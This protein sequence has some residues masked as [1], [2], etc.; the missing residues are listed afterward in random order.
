MSTVAVI[1]RSSIAGRVPDEDRL[2]VPELAS[3]SFG[4]RQR[5]GADP[6]VHRLARQLAVAR[7]EIAIAT[8]ATRTIVWQ[9]PRSTARS[10]S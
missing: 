5:I 7:S 4:S 10:L 8:R 2:L 1:C 3:D 6:A 9:A